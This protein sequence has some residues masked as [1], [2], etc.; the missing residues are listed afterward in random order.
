MACRRAPG[1]VVPRW[2][3]ETVR[4]TMSTTDLQRHRRLRWTST[5][6]E[7]TFVRIP[8]PTMEST[9]TIGG[10]MRC[11]TSCAAAHDDDDR[12]T[13]SRRRSAST[14]TTTVVVPAP[15]PPPPP[16]PWIPTTPRRRRP[17]AR[18]MSTSCPVCH[19]TPL[20]GGNEEQ[21]RRRHRVRRGAGA[22]IADE[23]VRGP[24][25]VLRDAPVR[26]G[27]DEEHGEGEGRL[28]VSANI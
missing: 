4:G 14:T 12:A 6:N 1:W 28:F 23:G 21:D 27:G 3:E 11:C 9:A 20:L 15:P 17:L 5:T 10:G 7:G 19:P 16:P 2:A 18:S 8:P 25:T 13:S 26:G 24:T 22:G